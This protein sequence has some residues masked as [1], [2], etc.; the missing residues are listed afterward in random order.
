MLCERGEGVSRGEEK[1]LG[2]KLGL[3]MT[4]RLS[5]QSTRSAV[6]GEVRIVSPV[7]QARWP[8]LY[9]WQHLAPHEEW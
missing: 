4:D 5:C 1:E 8:G 3:K 9:I 6:L 2:A 7:F